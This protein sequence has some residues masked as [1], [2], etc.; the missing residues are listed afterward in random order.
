MFAQYFLL[1]I[2]SSCSRSALQS[3]RTHTGSLPW[4]HVS[5]RGSSYITAYKKDNIQT[6]LHIIIY[7]YERPYNGIAR[8]RHLMDRISQFAYMDRRWRKKKRMPKNYVLCKC[9]C[10]LYMCVCVWCVVLQIKYL[11][12]FLFLLLC[13]SFTY[14]R[15]ISY[16]IPFAHIRTYARIRSAA[17]STFVSP[18][19][20]AHTW[21][22]TY[23]TYLTA[24]RIEFSIGLRI[25]SYI[26][27]F[28]W[29]VEGRHELDL[30][31]SFE[32][33]CST[34]RHRRRT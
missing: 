16:V 25:K 2:P 17:T 30:C 15:A 23:T 26:V 1:G 14:E 3:A 27:Y 33:I 5:V 24:H 29:R 13:F 11:S 8:Q 4:L 19:A 10:V 7:E 32:M 9:M 18:V 28:A 20:P 21:T 34:H 22:N 12:H 31:F 6:I